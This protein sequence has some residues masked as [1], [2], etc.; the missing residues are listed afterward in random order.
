MQVLDSLPGQGT[1][2]DIGAEVG[3]AAGGGEPADVYEPPDAVGLQGSEELFQAAGRM[4][5]GVDDQRPYL[6]RNS[7]TTSRKRRS[8]SWWT[9]CPAP[10][11][12]TT[13]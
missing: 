7:R 6:P 9:Q 3:V 12:T 5:D 8:W 1:G 4:T 11:M 2:E 10:S 13:R